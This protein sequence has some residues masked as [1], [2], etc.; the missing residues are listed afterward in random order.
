MTSW[1][2]AAD[3]PL[4][5]EHVLLGARF[6]SEGTSLGAPATYG[7]GSSEDASFD[8]GCALSDLSGM[9]A[10]LVS[11]K[12]VVA[13]AATV[14][15]HHELGVGECRFGAVLA[16]DGT[17]VSVPLLARTGDEEYLVLDPTGRGPSLPP[18]L[19]FLAGIEQGGLRPFAGVEVEDVSDALVPLLVW[20]RQANAI[21]GDYVASADELPAA[22]H[23]ANV[24]LDRIA[25]LLVAPPGTG[26]PCHLALVPPAAARV[27]WRSLLSFPVMDPVGTCALAGRACATFPWVASLRAGEHLRHAADDLLLWEL[28]RP[29]G[30]YVGARALGL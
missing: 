12:G 13:F 23:V 14:C 24:S 20:G 18:W 9:T 21:L 30:G 7:D 15:A 29:Q 6:A 27:L 17:T 5:G 19:C 28:V 3:A 1:N 22:G 16:G 10:T 25:C 26:H 2:G 8:Q 4:Y 11:G